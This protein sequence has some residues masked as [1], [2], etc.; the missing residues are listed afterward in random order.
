M[1]ESTPYFGAGGRVA[2]ELRPSNSL[3][4][5]LH[6]DLLANLTRTT[7]ELRGAEA[8]RAPPLAAAFRIEAGTGIW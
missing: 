5:R 3:F 2:S 8:W 4:I 1:D 6:L 7:L